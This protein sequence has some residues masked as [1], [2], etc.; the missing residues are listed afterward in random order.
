MAAPREQV[1]MPSDLLAKHVSRPAAVG[2]LP[3]PPEGITSPL[4]EVPL[5]VFSSSPGRPG[6]VLLRL[7]LDLLIRPDLTYYIGRE[8]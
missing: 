3:L 5:V 7:N 2:I 8:T 6:R 1:H 4:L